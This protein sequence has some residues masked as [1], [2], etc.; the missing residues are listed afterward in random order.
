MKVICFAK[1]NKKFY[2]TREFSFS[3][4]VSLCKRLT[5]SRPDRWRFRFAKFWLKPMI[6]I[7]ILYDKYTRVSTGLI[8][9]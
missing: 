5:G 8:C 3:R 6:M 4:N 9:D 7:M 2:G 1:A